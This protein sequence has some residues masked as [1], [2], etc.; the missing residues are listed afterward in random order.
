MIGK[1]NIIFIIRL[2]R[3]LRGHRGNRCWTG[4]G[5]GG[6]RNCIGSHGGCGYTVE[7][8]RV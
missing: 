8:L 5:E 7:T 1:V 4:R 3:S 6:E 2:W